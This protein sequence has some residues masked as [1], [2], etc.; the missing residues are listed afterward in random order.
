MNEIENLIPS[1][2]AA[3]MQ[4]ALQLRGGDSGNVPAFCQRV[5]E[6]QS[7]YEQKLANIRARS[8]ESGD[9]LDRTAAQISAVA[10]E[11]VA[12]AERTGRV[13]IAA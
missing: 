6:H 5:R 10:G 12:N 13:E 2:R 9:L 11:L 8:S 3:V 7:R 1:F 4:D